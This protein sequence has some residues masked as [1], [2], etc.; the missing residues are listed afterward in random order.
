MK[1]ELWVVWK[2]PNTRQRY[3]IGILTKH[4][5]NYSFRY[6]LEEK[7]KDFDY[8]PGFP[9]TNK[10]YN[11]VN[12]FTNILSRLPNPNRPDY[13]KIL[14]NYGLNKESSYMEILE[15]TRGRLI[16]DTYEFVLPFSRDSE[17][18]NEIIEKV[19]DDYNITIYKYKKGEYENE[20]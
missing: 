18:V 11:S 14:S 9:D 7:I 19:F 20:M 17:N 1:K 16:T 13:E 12:L 3:K 2:N 4:D 8:F 10:T 15:K 5:N 6:D